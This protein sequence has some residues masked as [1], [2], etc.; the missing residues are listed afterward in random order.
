MYL[1]ESICHRIRAFASVI[2]QSL[3]SGTRSSGIGRTDVGDAVQMTM[4]Q[5]QSGYVVR[6]QDAIGRIRAEPNQ[7]LFQGSGPMSPEHRSSRCDDESSTH[8]SRVQQKPLR[9]MRQSESLEDSSPQ[10]RGRVA[11]EAGASPSSVITIAS[12]SI[13]SR[14]TRPHSEGL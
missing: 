9:R 3:W 12:R 4:G 6:L 13:R 14:S 2:G 5:D 10:S 8:F 1:S 11:Y 7:G